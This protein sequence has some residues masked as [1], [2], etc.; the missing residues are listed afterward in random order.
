MAEMKKTIKETGKTEAKR[1]TEAKKAVLA[2]GVAA[3]YDEAAK[4]ILSRKIILGHILSQTVKEFRGMSP[5]EIV[6][7]IE[8]EPYVRQVPVDPGLT[9]VKIS[10]PGGDRIVGLN[11]ENVEVNEGV[12]YFDIIFYVRTR[13]G[14]STT[15]PQNIRQDSDSAVVLRKMIIGVEAQKDRPGSYQLLN[16]GIFYNCRMVSSQKERDFRGEDYDDIL[17]VHSIWIMMNQREHSLTHV[18]LTQDKLLGE[19]HWRGQM[20]AINV[21]MLGLGKELPEYDEEHKLHRLLGAIFST[22]VS[23][24]EKLMIMEKEYNIALEDEIR[25]D[26]EN[27]CSLSQ[28]VKEEG[29]EIGKEMGMEI[30]MEI[31]EE[32]GKREVAFRMFSKDQTPEM[33][34]DIIEKPMEYTMELHRQYVEMVHEKGTYRAKEK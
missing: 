27:M 5:E 25:R 9:N 23:R 15:A 19:V 11:T 6:P 20:D 34:S 31:G 4:C 14:Q 3:Q 29:I 32:I 12:C 21:H 28:Y 1:A 33:V 13:D 7:L 10:H 2:A 22:K 30:G 18:H 16:R 24:E 26:V 17:P 8:G